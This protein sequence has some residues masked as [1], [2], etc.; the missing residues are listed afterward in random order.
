MRRGIGHVSRN[1][2]RVEVVEDP[3]D[4][5]PGVARK[6][7]AV[8][9]ETRGASQKIEFGYGV[10]GIRMGRLVATPI[11]DE[12]LVTLLSPLDSQAVDDE[13]H[14]AQGGEEAGR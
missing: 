1:E 4:G 11:D 5:A 7:E 6:G 9:A 10:V 13:F 3:F 14:A 12:D 2:V 8:V